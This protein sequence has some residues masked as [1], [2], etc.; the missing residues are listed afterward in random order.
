MKVDGRA[1]MVFL[2]R[3]LAK[4]NFS[5]SRVTAFSLGEGSGERKL[6]FVAVILYLHKVL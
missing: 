6:S 2:Q 4:Q 3:N 1:E 5:S